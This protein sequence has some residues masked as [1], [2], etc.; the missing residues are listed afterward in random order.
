MANNY[1]LGPESSTELGAILPH[2]HVFVDLHLEH[3]GYAQ[4]G[5]AESSG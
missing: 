1:H 5:R 2:E 4:A 3:A